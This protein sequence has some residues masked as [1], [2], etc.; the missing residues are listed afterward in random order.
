MQSSPSPSRSHRSGYQELV[1]AQARSP[2]GSVPSALSDVLGTIKQS[3][4][5]QV[6]AN[7]HAHAHTHSMNSHTHTHTNSVHTGDF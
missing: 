5:T 1:S 3:P 7:T 2:N 4:A 6:G